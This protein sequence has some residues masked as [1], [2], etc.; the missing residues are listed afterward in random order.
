M[1]KNR[2]DEPIGVIIHIYTEMSQGNSL[3]SHIYLKQAKMSFFSSTKLENRRMEQ[4]LWGVG[5]GREGLVPVGGEGGR[6]RGY[7]SEY[8]AKNVYTH[9][10]KCKNDTC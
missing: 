4:V 3:Y 8:C 5:S 6:E 9:E 1:T 7:E 2:E 10:C